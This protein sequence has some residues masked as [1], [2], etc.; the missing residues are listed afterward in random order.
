MKTPLVLLNLLHQPMRTLVAI[1]GVSFA[2]L[3]IFMQLGFYDYAEIAATTLYD[4]LDFDLLLLSSNYVNS[5]RPRSFPLERLYQA[6]AHREVASV[7]PLYIGWQSWLIQNASGGQR[8]AILV[9]AFNLGDSIFLPDQVFRTQSMDVCLRRLRAPDTVLMDTLTR[10]YF[11]RIPIGLETELNRRRIR[12]VGRF[13]IGT[14]L[15]ADGMVLTSAETY[16]DLIG[17]RALDRPALGLIRLRDKDRADAVKKELSQ[18]L[19]AASP[20]D[21]VYVL[22][23][24]EIEK[25]E[26]EYW[27]K[28]TNVGIIFLMGVLIALIVGVIFVYQVIATDIADHYAEYATLRAMGYRTRF[29]SGIVLRQAMVLAVLGYVP[30]YLIAKGLYSL[31]KNKAELLL[32]MTWERL[33]GVLVLALAMCIVSG[34]LAMQKV[35]VADPADLF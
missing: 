28:H 35:K 33:A 21:E 7:S 16:S 15:G 2:V 20:R 1:L 23:R 5:T 11:G 27:M 9:L 32:E 10:R 34:L 24:K 22:T 13:T 31:L 30:A 6:R 14:G 17:P 25:A 18:V 3:L 29:L 12:V 26:R 8:R 19:Y 4:S